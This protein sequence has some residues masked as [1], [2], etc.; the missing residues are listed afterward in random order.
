MFDLTHEHDTNK[1]QVF[2]SKGW[3]LVGLGHKKVDP[4]AT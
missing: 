3:A 2:V 1:T 4:K